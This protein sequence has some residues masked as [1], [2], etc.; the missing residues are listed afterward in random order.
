MKYHTKN[1]QPMSE[2][3]NIVLGLCEGQGLELKPLALGV[4]IMGTDVVAS[5]SW[6]GLYLC[7]S[8]GRGL[9]R[10]EDG[11]ASLRPADKGQWCVSL[12]TMATDEADAKLQ[13]AML[14]RLA[15]KAGYFL[16]EL[17][18]EAAP[19]EPSAKDS[20]AREV[21]KGKGR[22]KKGNAAKEAAALD[23]ALSDL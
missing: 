11:V 17:P 8:S 16:P 14:L 19:V 21:T 18:E 3:L 13:A 22:R 12:G 5:D 1:G 6:R 9:G 2:P 10:A 20:A 7:K 4:R 15:K 23:A